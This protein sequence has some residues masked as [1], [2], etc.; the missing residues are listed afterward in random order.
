MQFFVH[1]LLLKRVRPK[2]GAEKIGTEFGIRDRVSL[3]LYA[4]ICVCE[5]VCVSVCSS[6]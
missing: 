3:S 2:T 4:Y 1:F 5:S 6:K